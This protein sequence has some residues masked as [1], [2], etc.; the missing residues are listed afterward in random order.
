MKPTNSAGHARHH[1]EVIHS[2]CRYIVNLKLLETLLQVAIEQ[3]HKI[4]QL[5]TTT[6]FNERIAVMIVSYLSRST[7][8]DNFLETKYVTKEDSHTFEF[9][10]CWLK[11]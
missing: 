6:V 3:I 9:L 5:E 7:V 10:D 4:N 8:S 1:H 11:Q 2:H